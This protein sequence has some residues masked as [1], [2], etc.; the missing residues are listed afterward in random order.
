[1]KFLVSDKPVPEELEEKLKEIVTRYGAYTIPEF[2]GAGV[3]FVVQLTFDIDEREYKDGITIVDIL[4]VTFCGDSDF[5]PIV[6]TIITRPTEA[7]VINEI[8]NVLKSYYG[9]KVKFSHGYVFNII[10]IP[11]KP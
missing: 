7:E 11:V 5:Y 3:S 4:S 10:G 6:E 9:E 2:I 8:Q 1:M